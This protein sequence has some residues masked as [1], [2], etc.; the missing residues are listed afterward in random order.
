MTPEGFC[1]RLKILCLL[2]LAITDIAYNI[3]SVRENPWKELFLTV[4]IFCSILPEET[5]G[6]LREKLPLQGSIYSIHH[7][8]VSLLTI[9]YP[10]GITAIGTGILIHA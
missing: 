2:F 6:Y 3:I 4:K 5:E 8:P 10:S 7:M 1:S 9:L